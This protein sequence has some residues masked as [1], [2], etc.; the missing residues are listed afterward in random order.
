MK[1]IALLLILLNFFNCEKIEDDTNIN[2]ISDCTT[3]QG[4]FITYN[5]VGVEGV[6]VSLK[7]RKSIG[8]YSNSTRLIAETY[9][10]KNGNFFKE[11]YVK[12]S[13]LGN[14]AEGYFN[15]EYDD[16]NLDVM[17]YILSDNLVG[18]TKQPL[19]QTLFT[20]NTRDTIF[21][22]TYYLPTKAHIKINLNNFVKQQDDDHFEVR[23]FYP[24]GPK[25]GSNNFLN[26]KYATGFSGWGTFVA[27]GLNNFL[28]VFVAENEEN[29]IRVY[30][31]KNGVSSREEFTIFVP[32]DNTI[33]LTYDY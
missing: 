7:Y 29:V 20:L 17:K 3:L 1:K 19:G 28:N 31:R 21:G 14:T 33:E 24:F 4:R 2:C 6:K 22:N 23:T 27:K 32:S 16:T 12:D 8:T 13:E 15:I 10:D 11:F 9:T 5:N 26:S 30:K 18:T 25:I